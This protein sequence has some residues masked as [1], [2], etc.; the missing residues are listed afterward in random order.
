MH[1]H[2]YE[3]IPIKAIDVF[4][5]IFL[6][7]LLIII[8]MVRMGKNINHVKIYQCISKIIS[9]IRM[10]CNMSK[11]TKRG[12]VPQDIK[13]FSQNNIKKLKIAAEELS[14]LL[15]RGYSIKSAITFIGNHYMLSVRQRTALMRVV[16]PTEYIH[17]RKNKQLKIDDLYGA[18]VHI[19]AFN[20]IITLEVALSHSM[21]LK[22]WDN[23]I[24]DLAGL[25]GTYKIISVTP[26]VLHLIYNQL[27]ALGINKATFYLDA[28]VSNSGRLKI[29]IEN[30]AKNYKLQVEAVILNDVDRTLETLTHVITS[31][32]I[33]LNKC[34][35]WINLNTEILMKEVPNAWCV[36]L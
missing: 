36:H 3:K 5:G 21:V 24:R 28:P 35:S 14:Y 32:A 1:Y 11:V 13:E 12:Y 23:T 8:K 16:S 2:P 9:C 6:S 15:D 27:L 19:D 7:I 4:I 29:L 25:R 18:E 26:M 31:D 34:K 20:T 22:C 30:E 10:L 17:L 33:V